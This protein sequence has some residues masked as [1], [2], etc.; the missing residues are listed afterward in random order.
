MKRFSS[1]QEVKE[2]LLGEFYLYS[3]R[4]EVINK[5]LNINKVEHSDKVNDVIYAS[6]KAGADGIIQKK[7]LIKFVLAKDDTLAEIF[8]NQGFIG[9]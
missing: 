8:V 7:W 6:I 1:E 3:T 4:S 9:T 2:F 5:W